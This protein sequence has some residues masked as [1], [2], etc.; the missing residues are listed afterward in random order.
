MYFV[1]GVFLVC[2][3]RICISYTDVSSAR[4]M[5]VGRSVDAKYTFS[6]YCVIIRPDIVRG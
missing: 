2:Y 3:C 6:Y 1:I 5:T 4:T